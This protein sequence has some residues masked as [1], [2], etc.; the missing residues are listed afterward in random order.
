MSALGTTAV[1]TAQ[2]LKA[3]ANCGA[4]GENAIVQT[5]RKADVIIGA[6]GIMLAHAMMGG[7]P[8]IMAEAVMQSPARKFLLPRPRKTSRWWAF[9][10]CPNP[11]DRYTFGR[12]S[13]EIYRRKPCVKQLPIW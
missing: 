8:P 6:I 9:L 13:P 12:A 4:S 10:P 2:M 7:V 3:G 11:C 1:A 5:S